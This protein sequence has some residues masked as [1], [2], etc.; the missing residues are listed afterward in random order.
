M[1][2]YIS[3][4]NMFSSICSLITAFNARP[5]ND[6][7]YVRH[8]L[9]TRSPFLSILI[10]SAIFRGARIPSFILI[11]A[12][13]V[14]GRENRSQRLWW[15]VYG[16]GPVI[17]WYLCG[18]HIAGREQHPFYRCWGLKIGVEWWTLAGVVVLLCPRVHG[19][20]G[21]RWGRQTGGTQPHTPIGYPLTMPW[22]VFEGQNHASPV[23][24][25]FV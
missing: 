8:F 2:P 18:Y 9:S 10:P 12:S 25:Y 14:M 6:W 11:A 23:S 3:C 20:G 24:H 19:L 15:Q 21:L 13:V 22:V 7:F 17:F 16:G 4:S 5:L 1:K